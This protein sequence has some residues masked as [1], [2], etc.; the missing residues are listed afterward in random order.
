[1]ADIFNIYK[2]L[3]DS[4]IHQ[5]L[6][7]NVNITFG[8]RDK[9]YVGATILPERLVDSNF[10]VEDELEFIATPANDATRYSQPIRQS[11]AEVISSRNIILGELDVERELTGKAF[12][13]MVRIAESSEEA[14]RLQLI[15]WMNTAL[16]ISLIEKSEI[17]RWQ[18][19][20]DGVVI[21]KGSDGKENTVTMD[22]DPNLTITVP[23]GTAQ[24]PTG[25]YGTDDPMTY[26]SAM[27]KA[28][29]DKGKTV[30]RIITDNQT[31][32]GLSMNPKMQGRLGNQ[33][34][35]P[36]GNSLTT[37]QRTGLVDVGSLNNYLRTFWGLPPLES[38]DLTYRTSDYKYKH[39]KSRG[40]MLFIGDSGQREIITQA[41][42][43]QPTGNLTLENTLGYYAVGLAVGQLSPGRVI[44]SAEKRLK[45]VGI[46]GQG[47]QTSFPVLNKPDSLGVIKF[48]VPTV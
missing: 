48:G 5:S 21:I 1:M 15:D 45:P 27:V 46:T 23:A 11:A 7:R 4:G 17:Q 26:I 10:L 42:N 39:F 13:D 29:S 22:R 28:L 12:D 37:E 41:G 47:F 6:A 19:L 8:R 44:V 2:K 18:M 24:N 30:T 3:V 14:A 31:I 9:P 20:E 25:L 35:V 32:S 43:L 34:F 36:S 38:Y 33:V 40:T 16:N